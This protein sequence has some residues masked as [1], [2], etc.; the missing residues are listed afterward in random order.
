MCAPLIPLS[1]KYTCAPSERLPYRS[2]PDV[3]PFRGG[4]G[5]GAFPLSFYTIACSNACLEKPYGAKSEIQLS[6]TDLLAF[7]SMK[8]AANV[9][10]VM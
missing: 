4:V 1:H 10:N 8:D 9:R 5:P 7:A 6:T 3:E 2:R